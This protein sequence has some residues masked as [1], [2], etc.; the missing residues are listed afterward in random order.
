MYGDMQ[1]ETY[2]G[3]PRRAAAKKATRVRP[4]AV[5]VTEV[6]EVVIHRYAGICLGRTHIRDK[7]GRGPKRNA[8]RAETC[9]HS[10]S[11]GA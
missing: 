8:G 3:L 2:Q 1:S 5:H 10:F 6:I 9:Q 11:I 7:S 4:R